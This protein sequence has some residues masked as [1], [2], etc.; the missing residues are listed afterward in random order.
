M[1]GVD[2]TVAVPDRPDQVERLE[3][4]LRDGLERLLGYLRQDTGSL[5]LEQLERELWKWVA[6]VYRLSVALFLAVRHRQLDLG[7]YLAAGWRVKVAFARRTIKTLGGPVTFGRAYL[8]RGRGHGW[9][10]LDAALGL[11]QDGFSWR[12]IDAVTRLATRVSYQAVRDIVG[13]LWGWSPSAEAIEG[14]VIGLGR[15]A[16]AFLA[17]QGQLA[18]D[19]EV[20]VIEVDGKAAPFATEAELAARRRKRTRAGCPCGR[21][22]CR[23]HRRRSRRAGRVRKRNTRGHNSK[24]GRSATLVVMYTL[25][26]GPDGRLHGPIN[27]KVWA[28]FGARRAAL[29]WARLQATR[30]GFGPDTTRLVQ[31]VVDGERCLRQ[32]LADLFANAT[33]TLDLRHAQER[34]WKAGRQFHAEAS[35][36][37]EAWVQ[38]LQTLLVAGRIGELLERLRAIQAAVASRGPG[39]KAKRDVLA[40]QIR[41]IEE[42]QDMMQY[43]RYRRDDL[44]LATGVVEG[45]C[46]HV[47]GERLDA[48]GMR[49]TLAGAEAVLQ[50]RCLE[51]NG[52]W[53]AFLGWVIRGSTTRMRQHTPVQIRRRSPA[54][55]PPPQHHQQAA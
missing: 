20:L 10:P 5:D 22:G 23:R 30:R 54:H 48:A 35:A 40:E 31:I 32:Q 26:R 34:L 24:N 53:N 7:G 36:A 55:D 27:K 44:V 8:R 28:Q 38:P 52:D 29:E 12:V 3:G 33:F 2:R 25:A 39:T 9:F 51:R 14:L 50:L 21:A 4:E 19:G 41:Y 45:A 13:G 47:L 49:W 11:S 18:G 1:D 16:A 42:R 43:G 6:Q 15:S 37:L 46:R 17:T